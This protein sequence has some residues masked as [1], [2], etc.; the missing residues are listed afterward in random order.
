MC[1][2]VS[3]T[4]L[5]YILRKYRFKMLLNFYSLSSDAFEQFVSCCSML[6]RLLTLIEQLSQT[7]VF[8]ECLSF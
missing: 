6:S 8:Q 1:L 2:L 5:Q 3:R 7:Q 4:T